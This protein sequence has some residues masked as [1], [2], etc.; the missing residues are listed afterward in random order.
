MTEV[1]VIDRAGRIAD[2]AAFDPAV[3]FESWFRWFRL[4]N[5]FLRFLGLFAVRSFD[6]RRAWTWRR[7]GLLRVAQA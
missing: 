3:K 4:L 7:G 2:N 1:V 6:D 5:D